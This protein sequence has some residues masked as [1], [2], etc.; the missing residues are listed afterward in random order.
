M[1]AQLEPSTFISMV[2]A[3][4]A[5]ALSGLIYW[6]WEQGLLLEQHL[7]T[8]RKMPATSVALPPVLPEFALPD[9]ESGFPELASRSPFVISRRTAPSSNKGGR[10]AM[11]K[12]QFV[13]VGVLVTPTQR[14]A[15]LRDIQTNK[16]ETVAVGAMVRGMTLAEVDATKVVLRQG[17]E[18]EELP[19][20]VQ[21]TSKPLS[22]LG[23]TAPSPSSSVASAPGHNLAPPKPQEAASAPVTPLP[24]PQMPPK[25]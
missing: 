16:T 9:A 6:E 12:G 3:G 25:K 24:P 14:S 4:L 20:M 17:S 22:T 5:L 1:R 2:L 19:L 15:M 23:V 7:M 13:L 8:L 18:T 11:K 21:I 10:S